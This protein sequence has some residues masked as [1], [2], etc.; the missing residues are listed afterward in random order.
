MPV[1]VTG[2]PVVLLRSRIASAVVV[3][4][5][6]LAGGLAHA[7]WARQFPGDLLTIFAAIWLVSAIVF[8]RNAILADDVGLLVRHRGRLTRS[9]RWDQIREAGPGYGSFG[10]HGI[11]VFPDGGPYDV[12]GPNSPIVVGKVWLWPGREVRERIEAVLRQHGVTLIDM[13]GRRSPG[14]GQSWRPR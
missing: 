14:D 11:A 9:Y 7:I 10:W 2:E 1:D 4:A 8:R 13:R 5:L 3:P 6:L 12:P